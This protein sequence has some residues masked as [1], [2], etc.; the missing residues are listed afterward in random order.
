MKQF[1][2]LLGLTT[3]PSRPSKADHRAPP[4]SRPSNIVELLFLVLSKA[5][6]RAPLSR[7]SEAI[8]EL[9]FLVLP[10]QI[11]EL[12]FPVLPRRSS[13]YL[14]LVLPRQIVELLLFLVLP[15]RSW[16]SSFSSFPGDR[17]APLSRPSRADRRV[18]P[19]S[20]P[21]Q[22]IVEL[23]LFLRLSS[24][25]QAMVAQAPATL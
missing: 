16:S 20:C 11:V 23:L 1:L 19:L 13:S 8:V 7:P 10:R 2:L 4:L 6:R 15:R 12:L 25:R 24:T 22:A 3:A 5:D 21:S 18:P 9:L 14:F 17:G